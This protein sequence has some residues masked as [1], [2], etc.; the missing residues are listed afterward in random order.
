MEVSRSS[1]LC[2]KRIT[3]KAPNLETDVKTGAMWHWAVG[4]TIEHGASGKGK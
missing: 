3:P 1:V 4:T 2:K